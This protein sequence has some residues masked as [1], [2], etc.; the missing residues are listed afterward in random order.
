MPSDFADL[1]RQLAERAEAVCRHYLSNGERHG[2][3][4]VVGNA[5]N[6]PGR[7]MFVRL[8]A[9]DG[10]K[11]RAGK[12]TDAAT[13]EHGDLLDIIA[14]SLGHVRKRDTLVE[15]RRFLSIAPS[16]VENDARLRSSRSS[17]PTG[18]P[19]AARRLFAAAR[20]IEGTAAERYL[21]TRSIVRGRSSSALRFHPGC[22]YR[23]SKDDLPGTRAAWPALIAA[24]TD[25]RGTITGVQRTWIDPVTFAKAPI[26]TPRRAIGNLLGHGVRF[27][28]AGTVMAVGEGVE[29]MLSVRAALPDMPMIAALSSAHLAALEFPPQLRRLYVAHDNDIAGE[30]ALARLQERAGAAG[31][32]VVPLTP[33]LDDFN[34]DHRLLDS[35]TVRRRMRP[36]LHPE[37]AERFLDEGFLI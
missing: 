19:E 27:G 7:S 6:S 13:A 35:D 9:R 17:K 36:Q 2:R 21:A 22:Y 12:W 10:D 28:S 23:P 16:P 31:I 18:T 24:V 33:E 25:M 26:A 1:A 3:Y 34:D 29:T 37:D 4:W 15:A 32:C 5:Y 8:I 30:G 14:L 11:G 20:A